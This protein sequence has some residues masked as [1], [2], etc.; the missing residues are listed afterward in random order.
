MGLISL[1]F[2]IAETTSSETE[3]VETSGTTADFRIEH[4]TTAFA[5]H[6]DFRVEHDTNP[7]IGTNPAPD[8]LTPGIGATREDITAEDSLDFVPIDPTLVMAPDALLPGLGASP[9]DVIAGT[10]FENLRI[11]HTLIVAEESVPDMLV[12]MQSGESCGV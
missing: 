7:V 11:E 3:L 8:A 9:G 10:G 5:G 6:L 2:G 1:P 12:S 4:D